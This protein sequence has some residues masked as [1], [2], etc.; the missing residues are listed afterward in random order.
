MCV[1]G[2]HA[3]LACKTQLHNYRVQT[4]SGI[5]IVNQVERQYNYDQIRSL[6]CSN[7]LTLANRL[8]LGLGVVRS[9]IALQ[10]V[11]T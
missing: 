11:H 3:L 6:L 1:C 4:N 8:L 10:S 5:K 7:C 2:M 9:L